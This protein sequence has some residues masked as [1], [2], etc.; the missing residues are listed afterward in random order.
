MYQHGLSAGIIILPNRVNGPRIEEALLEYRLTTSYLGSKE[1]LKFAKRS[2]KKPRTGV[3]FQMNKDRV[4]SIG[5]QGWI[6]IS[7]S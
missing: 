4:L 7:E 3:A 6:S 1:L 5:I 2:D